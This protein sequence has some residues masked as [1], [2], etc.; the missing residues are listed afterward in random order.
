MHPPPPPPVNLAPRHPASRAASTRLSRAGDETPRD[1][2]I[3]WLKFII[4]ARL[5]R[6]PSLNALAAFS[7]NTEEDLTSALKVEG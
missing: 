1:E 5:F 3:V 2:R 4:A 7:A 6:S